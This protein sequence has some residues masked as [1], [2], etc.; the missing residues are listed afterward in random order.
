M[1]D[2]K[3]PRLILP[4]AA[5]ALVAGCGPLSTWYKPDTPVRAVEDAALQCRVDATRDVPA[6]L[7]T[8]MTPPQVITR[9]ECDKEGRCRRVRDIIPG[10]IE[11]YDA[12]DDLREQVY[13]RCMT[14]SGH[15]RVNIPLCP[16]ELRRAT[17]QARTVV[18]PR[19]QENACVIR[20]SDHSWQ[21]V[22]PG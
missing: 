22:N 19:L 12:N 15:A 9:R 10:Q 16:V 13:T 21:I 5:L 14:R 8:R 18:F 4:L 1:P 7:R 11:T 20:N 6:S 2:P 3:F 17:P